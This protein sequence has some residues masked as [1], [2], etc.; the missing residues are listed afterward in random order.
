MTTTTT[1]Q[2]ASLQDNSTAALVWTVGL[3]LLVA[4]AGA[5]G[6]M[7]LKG[8]GVL[9]QSLPGC[10]PESACD[11]I[12][13][14]PFGSIPGI[15]WPVSFLGFAYFCGLIIAWSGCLGGVSS[16]LR[17]LIRLGVVASLMFIV[18]MIV[19][20]ALCPYCL[21]THLCNIAFW[22]LVEF[23]PGR[24]DDVRLPALVAWL[25]TFAIVSL[26]LG[27][28]DAHRTSI[29]EPMHAEIQSAK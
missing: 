9:G 15:G 13:R 26:G 22:G 10:G 23:S 18:V 28:G 1:K 5:S 20:G 27:L 14:G 24:R 16:P 11:A 3:L 7:A 17:W 6:I 21:T 4:A 8:L 19:D 25:A 2:L 12:T 29:L